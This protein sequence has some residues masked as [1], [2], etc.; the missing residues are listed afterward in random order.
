MLWFGRCDFFYLSCSTTH[1]SVEDWQVGVQPRKKD[2]QKPQKSAV[3]KA[4]VVALF[5]NFRNIS[6]NPPSWANTKACITA[7]SRGTEKECSMHKR[8][9]QTHSD[10]LFVVNYL[11]LCLKGTQ[12][13]FQQ[14]LSICS[15]LSGLPK[16]AILSWKTVRTEDC[17]WKS[18][19]GKER[20]RGISDEK[21]GWKWALKSRRCFSHIVFSSDTA[22]K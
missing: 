11:D 12:G 19:H 13:T 22:R 7:P 14:L 6:V 21:L 16:L 15:V 18:Y 3:V 5:G 4:V 8:S 20:Q 17:N 2:R 9:Q 10:A 1:R